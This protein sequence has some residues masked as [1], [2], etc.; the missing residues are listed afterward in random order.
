MQKEPNMKNST[1]SL[2]A[3][4]GQ[5]KPGAGRV[6]DIRTRL[7]CVVTNSR[8]EVFSCAGNMPYVN[9]DSSSISV[10]KIQ[11]IVYLI[12]LKFPACVLY[13]KFLL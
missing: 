6:L 12:F 5:A 9:R 7:S 2:R 8:T 13:V 1:C 3:V 4:Q 11:Q 10:E